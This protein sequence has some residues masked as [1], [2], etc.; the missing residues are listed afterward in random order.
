MSIASNAVL[1]LGCGN[2]DRS[3]DAAGLLVV[4]RL[5]ELGVDAYEHSGETLA[6]IE[7]WSGSRDVVVV[8][9]VLS[10]APPGTITVWDARNAPLPPDQFRC[11]THAVGLAEAIELARVLDRL[12]AKLTLY[13]IEVVNF[14]RGGAVSPRIAD[15]IDWPKTSLRKRDK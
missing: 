7:T 3:D 9:A 14:E 12:P 5:R 11:S 4:R 13:G 2:A 6:L 1:I 10:G 15:A 8:D